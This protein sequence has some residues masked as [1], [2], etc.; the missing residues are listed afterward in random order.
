VRMARFPPPPRGA[1]APPAASL[2]QT[3]SEF[4]REFPQG[5]PAGGQRM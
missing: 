4:S 3:S 2:A 1:E 5:K